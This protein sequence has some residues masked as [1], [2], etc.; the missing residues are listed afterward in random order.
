MVELDAAGDRALRRIRF[1]LSAAPGHTVSVA[2]IFNDWDP[3]A[4]VME[5]SP[6]DGGY[7]CA[8]IL[9]PGE[10]E[11]KFIVDG[12]WL[13]DE[14]NPNFVSNDFGTLNSILSVE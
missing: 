11:Y 14:S 13:L 1:R 2:G 5:Y 3:S 8:V 7:S 10:Y 6:E 12:E 9:P 4:D